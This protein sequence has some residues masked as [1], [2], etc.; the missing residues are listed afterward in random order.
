MVVTRPAFPPPSAV[1][2]PSTSLP[3]RKGGVVSART[4][5]QTQAPASTWGSR[6]SAAVMKAAA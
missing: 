6:P 5:F 3:V 2:A 4:S 1:Q